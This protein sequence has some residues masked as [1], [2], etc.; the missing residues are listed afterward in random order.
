M[1]SRL[2]QINFSCNF[3]LQK[4]VFT[5]LDLVKIRALRGK[6]DD[7]ALALSLRP[8]YKKR[9]LRLQFWHQGVGRE[10]GVADAPGSWWATGV[11][12]HFTTGFREENIQVGR[13]LLE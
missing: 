13:M 7:A 12:F 9:L 2:R 3:F 10:Q 4:N 6:T 11:F 8:I 1:P 5:L